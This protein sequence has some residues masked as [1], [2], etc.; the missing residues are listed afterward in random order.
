MTDS[1]QP[2][3]RRVLLDE[4]LPRQLVHELPSHD[5]TTVSAQGWRGVLNGEL[6]RRAE[7]AGFEVFV[8]ADRNLEY[9]QRI[10]GRSLG[11]IVLV[12]RR[13]KL[14]F[15]RPL[16]PGLRDAIDVIEAGQVI[17]VYPPT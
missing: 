6:I 14:E 11:F 4:N 9:Q 8:T 13:L 10:P 5:A 7:A 3:R 1:S 15:L 12:T 17:H 2:K 16:G